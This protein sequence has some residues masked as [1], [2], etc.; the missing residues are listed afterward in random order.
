MKVFVSGLLNI[1]T[2]VRIKEF[3]IEYYPIDYNFFGVNSNVSGVG[4]NISK[5]LSTLG[6]T[7]SLKSFLGNDDEAERILNTLKKENIAFNNIEKNLKN[8]PCSAVLYD[9]NGKR[10][11]YCDLKDIQEKRIE[12][13][14]KIISE[15]NSCDTAVIC[16]INFNR[17]LI[18]AKNEITVPIATDVHVLG[19]IEDEYNRDFIKNS[20]ILF[21]SDEN[22]PCSAVEF[23]KKIEDRYKNKIIVIGMGSKG[24]L[25]LDS[26]NQKIYE[27]GVYE[28]KNV[29]NTVG[30]GDTLFSAFIHFYAKENS[31][32]D[33]MK[34]AEIFA[35]KKISFNGAS[36]GFSSEKEIEKEFPGNNISVKEL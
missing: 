18:K 22:L 16:N 5:A 29:V 27:L 34:K 19:D 9:E 31:P 17:E 13:D 25:L 8:T 2:T 12:P 20:D 4:F 1:E 7:V 26:K 10:Q 35:S 36:L 21:L 15:I 33:A 6:D 32:L 28:N 11:I 3:P 14:K 24:A 30:A 23:I